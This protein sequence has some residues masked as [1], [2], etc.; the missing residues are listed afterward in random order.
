MTTALMDRP[1]FDAAASPRKPD[2]RLTLEQRLTRTWQ[3]L[4]T[5][6]TATCPLC[7]EPMR[8]TGGA[9]ECTSCG[10]TLS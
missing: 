10:T 9:G 6:G 1:L 8:N 3:E 2:G 4:Q 7:H 5:A